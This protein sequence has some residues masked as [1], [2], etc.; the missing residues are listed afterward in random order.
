MNKD[1]FK[2]WY[3]RIYYKHMRNSVLRFLKG[4]R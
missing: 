1:I 4:I 3:L 2:F